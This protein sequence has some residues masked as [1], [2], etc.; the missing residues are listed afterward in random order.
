MGFRS[1]LPVGSIHSSEPP[2][3]SRSDPAVPSTTVSLSAHSARARSAG[4]YQLMSR[5]PMQP[6]ANWSE[7][8]AT[9]SPMLWEPNLPRAAETVATSPI[10][11]LAVSTR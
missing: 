2:V 11:N 8:V 1:R 6:L 5:S 4:A 9:S 3:K 10:K 7:S